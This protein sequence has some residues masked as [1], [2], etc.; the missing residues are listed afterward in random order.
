[1]LKKKSRPRRAIASLLVLIIL[2]F[3]VYIAWNVLPMASGYGAKNLCSCVFVAQRN[4][5]DVIH[6][7]LNFLPVNWGSYQI[8]HETKTVTGSVLG[9][10][11]QKAIFREGFGCTLVNDLT[12]TEIRS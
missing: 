3:I 8:H 4:D 11:K 1:M 5:S 12:E 9:L 6:N 7:E 10:A 2:V